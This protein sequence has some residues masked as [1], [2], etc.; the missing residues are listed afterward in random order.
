M[1]L[2]SCCA[3]VPLCQS[4]SVSLLCFPPAQ[5]GLLRRRGI[6]E[7]S[8]CCLSPTQTQT[9]PTMLGAAPC[10]Y[11]HILRTRPTHHKTHPDVHVH[12]AGS[13]KHTT[14]RT[15]LVGYSHANMVPAMLCRYIASEKGQAE[16]VCLLINARAELD[17]ATRDDVSTPLYAA[18]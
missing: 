7:L 9:T 12:V 3:D 16:V 2:L 18:S 13:S 4:F 1:A 10:A 17:L 15:R 14:C 5:S 11:S 6:R 8:G